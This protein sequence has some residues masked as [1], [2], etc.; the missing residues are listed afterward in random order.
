MAKP[1]CTVD[2]C[3]RPHNARGL[4]ITHY[5]RWKKTGDPQP[6]QP[7]RLSRPPGKYVCTVDGCD[8]PEQARGWCQMHYSRW[9]T[10]GDVQAEI[11]PGAGRR[12][13]QRFCEICGKATR[14][15]R[16]CSYHRY[17]WKKYG[18]PHYD[19][20][21][22]RIPPP[23]RPKPDPR[24]CANEEMPC[25][26]MAERASG[27]CKRC[28]IRIDK[29]IP[30]SRPPQR[31]R[32]YGSVTEQAADALA[33]ARAAGVEP[34]VPFPGAT[35]RWPAVCLRCAMPVNVTRV[36]ILRG[37][38]PCAYCAGIRID[39]TIAI[40]K[41]MARDFHP[42]VPFPGAAEKWPGVCH[43]CGRHGNPRYAKVGPGGQEA[44]G[45]CAGQRTDLDIAMA[46]ML[47]R[48]FLPSVPFQGTNR[49]WPGVC[50]KCGMHGSPTP[51]N[52]WQQGRT[53]CGFCNGKRV[54]DAVEYGKVLALDFDPIGP[55]PGV[56]HD[57]PGTCL[58]CGVRSKIRV[59]DIKNGI[60]PCGECSPHGG[61]RRQ[62]PG[63]LYFMVRQGQQQI[64]I[65]NYPEK[66]LE[67]HSKLGWTL[68]QIVGPVDGGLVYEA[69]ASI[70]AW[71][72]SEVG[73]IPGTYENWYSRNFHATRLDDIFDA[74]GVDAH[75]LGPIRRTL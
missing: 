69:E 41:M 57:W 16:F 15:K 24:P 30:L 70:R 55:F 2:G 8:K 13:S 49:P 28:Q 12:K 67:T 9:A 26:R 66:R 46:K 19:V 36:E 61:F 20:P 27:Y 68:V 74:A 62:L 3:D 44:C 59:N 37:R 53:A 32:T 51:G 21:Q 14:Y 35:A 73:T 4:C 5:T 11:A 60:S 25:D 42:S 54:D 65:T 43:R 7:V 39:P 33:E 17:R 23:P 72:K 10:H 31:K 47:A 18:D 1:T 38:E 58:R 6:D 63:W 56:M 71:L 48:D 50:L 29:G 45:Y 64:G 75:P 40:G 22:K 34:S 52:A